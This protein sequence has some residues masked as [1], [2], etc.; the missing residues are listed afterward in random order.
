MV[1]MMDKG[2]GTTQMQPGGLAQLFAGNQP[3]VGGTPPAQIPQIAAPQYGGALTPSIE[4]AM[5]ATRARM[6]ARTPVVA[7][8]AAPQRQQQLY[9]DRGNGGGAR[10]AA[11]GGNGNG[12]GGH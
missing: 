1:G 12:W 9:V 2:T 7:P 3:A 6:L 5:A 8:V 10:G 11:S 4:D